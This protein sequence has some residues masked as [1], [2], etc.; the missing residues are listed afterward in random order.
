[1]KKIIII[2]TL[3]AIASSSLLLTSSYLVFNKYYEVQKEKEKILLQRERISQLKN[4]YNRLLNEANIIGR[5]NTLWEEIEKRGF[6]PENME[7]YSFNISSKLQWKD[8]AYLLILL[9]QYQK[10]GGNTFF[11]PGQFVVT[12]SYSEKNA[13]NHLFFNITLSGKFLKLITTE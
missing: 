8:T 10:R 5:W 12:P 9:N 7:T 1:M 2:K 3:I 11:V 6:L 13:T 4:I